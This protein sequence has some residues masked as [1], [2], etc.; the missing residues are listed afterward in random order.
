MAKEK[1]NKN[2]IKQLVPVEH[3]ANYEI[4]Q[5]QDMSLLLMHCSVWDLIKAGDQC[6]CSLSS[7]VIGDL[8]HSLFL[9]GW[10]NG[11]DS[12]MVQISMPGPTSLIWAST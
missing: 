8:G 7:I 6:I 3:V 9:T 5:M 2:N 11:S 4:L 10:H 1:V 12:Q